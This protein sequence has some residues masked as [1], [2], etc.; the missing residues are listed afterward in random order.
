MHH[1]ATKL[2]D[3]FLWKRGAYIKPLFWNSKLHWLFDTVVHCWRVRMLPS[4]LTFDFLITRFFYQIA[5]DSI[6]GEK[7]NFISYL[8]VYNHW[9]MYTTSGRCARNE[10]EVEVGLQQ[11]R[12]REENRTVLPKNQVFMKTRK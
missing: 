7:L 8:E 3:Y 6:C 1:P 10:I 9:N 11:C 5:L 4:R 12:P 2:T